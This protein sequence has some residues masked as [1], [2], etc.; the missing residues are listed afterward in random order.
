MF[1]KYCKVVC[2]IIIASFFSMILLNQCNEGFV[3]GSEYKPPTLDMNCAP[4]SK[5]EQYKKTNVP[6]FPEL[7]MFVNN[8]QSH[9]CCPSPYT[10]SNGCVCVTKEQ[11]KYLNNRGGNRGN[12]EYNP[13][14]EF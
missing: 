14:P 7:S 3:T 11:L 2:V 5:H 10:G 1:G 13:T 9:A 8:K 12:I 4:Y 6:P